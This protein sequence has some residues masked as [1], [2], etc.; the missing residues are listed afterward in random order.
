MM[1]R[2]SESSSLSS[3]DKDKLDKMLKIIEPADATE[4]AIRGALYQFLNNQNMKDVVK[5]VITVERNRIVRYKA[6]DT[7][8]KFR[9][10]GSKYEA[11][12]HPDTIL[13]YKLRKKAKEFLANSPPAFN[14]DIPLP[15]TVTAVPFATTV[16]P[17]SWSI[18]VPR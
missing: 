5:D 3:G 10:N 12:L 17:A 1:Q 18:G 7:G 15:V 16:G 14:P 13:V 11:A 8:S 4:Q 9:R 2:L 6:R